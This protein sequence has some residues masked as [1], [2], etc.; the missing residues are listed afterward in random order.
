I[1]NFNEDTAKNPSPQPHSPVTSLKQESFNNVAVQD[2]TDGYTTAN[3][4]PNA[5]AKNPSPQ[6]HSPVT[7]LK[8]E[9]SN[10]LRTD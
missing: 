5:Q 1:T 7:S 4:G 3:L 8:Q 9:S 6:S 2:D 10:N